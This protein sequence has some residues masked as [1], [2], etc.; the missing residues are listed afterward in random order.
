MEV[1]K[2]YIQSLVND[3]KILFPNTDEYILWISAVDYYI[4]EVLKKEVATPDE[5]E[6]LMKNAN[7]ESKNRYYENIKFE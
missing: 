5:I 6:E 3:S 4:K 1:D 7:L 2:E